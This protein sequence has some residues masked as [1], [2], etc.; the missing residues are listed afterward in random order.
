M[1]KGM[2]ATM[3]SIGILCTATTAQTLGHAGHKA[4]ARQVSE[5]MKRDFKRT[6]RVIGRNTH[7]WGG[8]SVHSNGTIYSDNYIVVHKDG[9]Y[10]MSCRY[11]KYEHND[12]VNEDCLID[13]NMDGIIDE[14]W[15]GR[16]REENAPH[17]R[18]SRGEDPM[19]YMRHWNKVRGHREVLRLT[20]TH[21]RTTWKVTGDYRKNRRR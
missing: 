12:I 14:E 21:M 10:I 4:D 8:V 9:T 18:L 15:H 20:D 11:R 7:Y 2:L 1:D 16:H 6:K 13:R 19:K 5:V 3:I 17:Y